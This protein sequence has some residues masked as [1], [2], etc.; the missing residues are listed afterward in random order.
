MINTAIAARSSPAF[1][2]QVR[3]EKERNLRCLFYAYPISAIRA[4]NLAGPTR[5]ARSV[6]L[7]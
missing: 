3:E 7:Q 6:Q 1:L 2:L 5:N 4:R